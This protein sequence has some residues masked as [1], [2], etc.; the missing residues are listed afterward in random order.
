MK[1]DAL[2]AI[3]ER[4]HEERL[5][6]FLGEPQELTDGRYLYLYSDGYP[7]TVELYFHD[8]RVRRIEWTYWAEP[9]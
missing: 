9:Q 4:R 5:T 3:G 7:D 2:Q 8:G 1:E 6:P